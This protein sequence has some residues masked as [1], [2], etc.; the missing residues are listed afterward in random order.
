MK[1]GQLHERLTAAADDTKPPSERNFGLTFAIVFAVIGFLPLVH[2]G[3]LRWWSVAVS[4]ILLV[5]TFLAPSAL[6]WPNQQWFRFGLLLHRI[7]NPVVLGAMF[8]L[9]ITPMALFMRI[10]GKKLLNMQYDPD[11]KSYWIE[12]QPP[13]PSTESVRRQF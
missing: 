11:A 12:R 2:G 3:A 5:V 7:V 13:G 1:S 10:L 8:F 9:A 4:A 6:R